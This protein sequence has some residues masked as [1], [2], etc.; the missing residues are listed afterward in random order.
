MTWVMVPVTLVT[1]DELLI[2]E[3]VGELTFVR[4]C[5]WLTTD[6]VGLVLVATNN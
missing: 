3:T 6:C 2:I 5:C 4:F 1:T